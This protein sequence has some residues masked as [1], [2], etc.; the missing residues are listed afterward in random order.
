MADEIEIS[1]CCE[2]L[3]DAIDEGCIQVGQ[4][5]TGEIVELL[6]GPTGDGTLVINFCPF[7]GTARPGAEDID[8]ED[9][10]DE[11]SARN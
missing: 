1:V 9:D 5:E 4:L 2:A 3:G 10:G 11:G 7:C 8:L 6:A